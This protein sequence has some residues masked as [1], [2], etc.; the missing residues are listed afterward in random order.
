VDLATIDHLLT[1]TR[2]VRALDD[3]RSARG[4]ERYLGWRSGADRR[5]HAVALRRRPDPA[6]REAIAGVY[7]RAR[8]AY[9]REPPPFLAGAYA[10]G[11]PRV[12]LRRR[13]RDAGE[14]LARHLQDVPV[15]ILGCIEGRV[16]QAGVFA[17][18]TLYGSIL[19]A[20]WSLWALCASR[21]SLA[22]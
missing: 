16:E 18:A 7:R 12:D 6:L 20:A 3:A 19:P 22:S 17:Q 4:W 5:L 21:S 11:D 2:T 10:P 13:M 14:H 15:L 9:H 1:T 8:A